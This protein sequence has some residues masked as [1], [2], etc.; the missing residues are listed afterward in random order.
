MA[1]KKKTNSETI[2]VG[3][4][5]PVTTKNGTYERNSITTY[6]TSY[7]DKAGNTANKASKYATKSNPYDKTISAGVKAV[8]G[9]QPIKSNQMGAYLDSI[10]KAMGRGDFSDPYQT[11]KDSLVGDINSTPFSS[12]YDDQVDRILGLMEAGYDPETDAN[13][14][15]YKNAYTRGGQ[16][17][18]QNTMAQA[19]ALT[20]GYGSS[21]G[22]SVGQQTYN[23]YMAGLADK[24]PELAAA[25]QEMYQNQLNNYM[26]L[27]NRD[28][29]R[30]E[31]NRN[32]GLNALGALD[33]LSNTA[34]NAYNTNA[35]QDWQGVNALGNYVGQDVNIQG[36]NNEQIMNQLGQYL[37]AGNYARNELQNKYNNVLGLSD[38]YNSL[39]NS[40]KALQDS[41]RAQ[42]EEI[43][44]RLE[45]AAKAAAKGSGGSGGG[46]SGSSS[47]PETI[48][49]N[50]SMDGGWVDVPTMGKQSLSSLEQL[51]KE[52]KIIETATKD[53]YV[54][55]PAKKTDRVRYPGLQ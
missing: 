1:D 12:K 31:S 44:D 34:M 42:Y 10:Q 35:N 27:G 15:N 52:G 26:N 43:Q 55:S 24:I 7:L 21:Y 30:Y 39:F 47:T 28:F 36:M 37:N 5:Q 51:V 6:D 50:H 33:N 4:G 49:N 3:L 20:G 14:Q 25:A 19:A 53:G 45:A 41:E 54:Y 17:A 48:V 16:Q 29:S 22:Q 18:M 13:Y 9:L 11:M 8:Q 32:Y 46:R 38:T 2:A 23:Q 40:T